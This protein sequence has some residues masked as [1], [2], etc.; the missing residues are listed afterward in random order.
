M[1]LWETSDMKHISVKTKTLCDE[2]CNV[3]CM[4]LVWLSH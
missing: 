2:T 4:L 3:L 1:N